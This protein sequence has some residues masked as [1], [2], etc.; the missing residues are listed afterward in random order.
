VAVFADLWGFCGSAGALDGGFFA[1][2]HGGRAGFATS[3]AF[4][5]HDATT[6]RGGAA[7]AG[8]TT[9]GG[10]VGSAGAVVPG[11]A[12]AAGGLAAGARVV[13]ARDRV[14]DVEDAIASSYANAGQRDR[15]SKARKG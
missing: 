1:F 7:F 14:L 9:L 3:A 2:G 4:Y 12:A 5:H 10:D 15:A 8:F 11:A 6:L 13:R